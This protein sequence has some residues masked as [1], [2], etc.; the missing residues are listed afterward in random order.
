MTK[1]M[2]LYMVGDEILIVDCG[3]GF[4]DETMV[5]VDLLIPDVSYLINLLKRDTKKRIVGMLLSHGHEDHIGALSYIIPQLPSFPIYASPLTAALANEK[6]KEYRIDTRVQTV[7]FHEPPVRLGS[8]TVSFIRITHSVPDSTNIFIKTPVGNFYHG[9]DYKLDLTPA[10][11]KKSEY[12]KITKANKEGV[13]ALFSDSLGAERPGFTPTELPLQKNFEMAMRD[14]KGK[15]LITT[16][17]SNI[18]RINQGI[19]VA[20]KLGRK[21]CFVG[22]SIKK[23]TTVAKELGYMKIP[24]GIEVPVEAIKKID[25]KDLLLFVAGSQ[26]QENSSLSRIAGGIHRE[27]KL[28]PDD[29]VIFSADTIPGNEVLVRALVDDISKKG[30]RVLNSDTSHDF[31]VS[32]H[33]Y[34]G[35]LM[36]MMSLVGAKYVVPISGTYTS[37]I[38]YRE[39]A[40]NLGYDSKSV[41]LPENGQ[42]LLFSKSGVRKGQKHDV[43]TVYVDEVSGEEVESFVLRDRERLAKE[44]VI[45]VF[46]EVKKQTGKLSG[47]PD[48]TAK[49]FSR[50]DTVLLTKEL[51]KELESQFTQNKGRVKTAV[52]ARKQIEDSVMRYVLR[53]LSKKPLVL[54]IV[55]EV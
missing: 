51:P 19:A 7:G 10:D 39:L 53:K 25:D 50:S 43:R 29:L 32:G 28:T 3:I 24:K 41:F 17:S 12:L 54:P 2:Y 27:I 31:H 44:G 15:I 52:H 21:I 11:G 26:G 36:L 45:I 13:L 46:T 47:K 16:Y 55:M 23:A 22:R 34:A 35:D 14:V 33:G 42:E 49:G 37:M 8:F 1:N 38:A 9:S 30:T 48:I 20:K 18:A 4:A 6:L 5:G 40:K